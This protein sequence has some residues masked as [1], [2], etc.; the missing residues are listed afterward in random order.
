MRL[1]YRAIRRV[2]NCFLRPHLPRK[3]GYYNGVIVRWP[4]LFDATDVVPD[5]EDAACQALREVVEPG[6]TVLIIGGGLGVTAIKAARA[7]GPEGRVVV[8]EASPDVANL[9]FE[10]LDM[11]SNPGNIS[12]VRSAVGP[13]KNPYGAAEISSVPPLGLPEA[14]V[15]EIDAEGA[16]REIVPA[17]REATGA[18]AVIVETHGCW[19]APTTEVRASLE[20]DYAVQD[21]GAEDPDRDIRTLV[22]TAGEASG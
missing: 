17:I 14:D 16:E 12:I 11:N 5:H 19:G 20:T 3:L 22:A 13:V 15:V 10:T 8:Y 7:T 2:Y 9:L 4:R 6:D 18:R 21:A 1:L